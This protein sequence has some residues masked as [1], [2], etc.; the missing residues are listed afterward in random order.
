MTK[1]QESGGAPLEQLPD[2][3]LCRLIRE[4]DRPA[5]EVLA[6]RYHRVVRSCARPYFLAGGDSEDLMQEGMFGLIKAMREYDPDLPNLCRNVYPPPAL[7]RCEGCG[8]GEARP[9]ESIGS[10]ESLTL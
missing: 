7:F 2:E 1:D 9:I 10:L 4:Q 8:G 3:A 5:E 6:A